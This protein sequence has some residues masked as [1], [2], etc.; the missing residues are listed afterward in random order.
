MSEPLARPRGCLSLA[1]RS[2]S[3][4]ELIAPA[5]TITSPAEYSSGAPSRSTETFVTTRPVPS[6]CSRVTFDFVLRVTLGRA[7]AGSTQQTWASALAWTRHGNP[8]QV[9]HRIH[10]E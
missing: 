4:A 2:R 10:L 3:A 5:A 7:R 9:S 6:V 8:S 1:E